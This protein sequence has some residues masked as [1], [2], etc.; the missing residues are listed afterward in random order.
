MLKR[1][2]VLLTDWQTEHLRLVA[3][4]N[5][6]SF[7]EM[8][9]ILLCE[10]LLYSAISLHPECNTK[11]IKVKMGKIASEG[12]NPKTSIE[13]KHKLISELYFEARKATECI[14]KKIEAGLKGRNGKVNP[15]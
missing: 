6:V 5:D 11:A 15:V 3:K 8:I 1:H 2:Q 13:R 9:R 14:N 10:G 4:H 7:S 12:H